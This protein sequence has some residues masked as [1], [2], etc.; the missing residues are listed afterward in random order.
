M[1]KLYP[2]V[3]GLFGL[4][5]AGCFSDSGDPGPD[6]ATGS[7]GIE[8]ILDVS[9]EDVPTGFYALFD[10]SIGLLPYPND[11]TGFL[12]DPDTDGTL[13]LPADQLVFQVLASEVNR[14][15]GFS[16]FGRITVNFSDG[17]SP[18]S[19]DPTANP[20]NAFAV[21]V[22]EVIQDPA[23]KAVVGVAGPPL[24]PGV[25]FSVSVADDVGSGGEMLEIKPLKPLNPKSGYLVI[26]SNQVTD[27]AG[28]PAVSDATYEQIKQG[29]LAGLIQ[30][31]P[32]GTP[33]PPLSQDELLALFIAA[34]LAVVDGLADAGVPISVENT[35][36]TASFSTLSV[37]DALDYIDDTA[38]AQFS[39]IEQT[40]APVDL[41]T[42]GGGILPAGTPITTG[43][44]LSLLG[45][46]SQCGPTAGFQLPGCG[47]VFAGAMNM[48]YFLE[49]P[50][51][52]NDPTA[53]TSFWEG[54]PGVNPLDPDSITLS[55]YNPVANKK[56]DILIPAIMAVPGPNSQYVQAGGS[57]PPTGW[58]V[59]IYYH[60]VT[61]NRLDMFAVAEGW[62]NAGVAVIAIDHPLHGITAVDPATDPTALFRVPGT[63]ERTFDLDL[64]QNDNPA[65]AEPDGLIDPSGVHYLNPAP[66]R[67]LPTADKARESVNSIIQLIRTIPTID[68]DGDGASDLDGSRIHMVGESLGGWAAL[69]TAVVNDE[70]VSVTSAYPASSLSQALFESTAFKPLA[71]GLTAALAASGILP[72]TTA[73][74]NYIRDFQNLADAGDPINY[75]HA[76]STDQTVPIHMFMVVGDLVAPNESTLRLQNAMGLP[77]VPLAQPPVFPFPVLVGSDDPLQGTGGVNGGFLIF[78]AGAHGSLISPEADP[79]TTVEMQTEAVVFGVGNPPAMIPGNGQVILI[80]DPTVLDVDGP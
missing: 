23:T 64:V 52:Q 42:P 70:L 12:A 32:P 10:P 77:Q 67:L 17:I 48:P 69:D 2:F 62:N 58:P 22:I 80:S 54:T 31:P 55:R 20:L 78:T 16:T 18:Q 3:L 72:G 35:V 50:A 51:N 68:I 7:T 34:H 47:L 40:F 66:D 33:L 11:I 1:R 24:Q 45:F 59:M 29:Y 65:I 74:E 9:P 30:L 19:I 46:D 27:T 44:V 73:F 79:A 75:G 5:L 49:P 39:Q 15:D 21:V 76:W 36:V 6:P 57:K 56:A 25:D 26:V 13:N 4:G 14:L 8:E 28:T 71:D 41:P 38:T 61:R 37:T 60:G 43:I 53:I 63:T